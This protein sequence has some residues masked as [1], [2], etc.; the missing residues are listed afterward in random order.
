M[1]RPFFF[2]NKKDGDL[3]PVKDYQA[4]ND[5]TIKN[6][7]PLP[8]IPELID[9][10]HGA[11]YYTKFNVR[12]GYNN[13][14]IKEGDKWK[15][16]FKM[17]LGLFQPTVMTFGLCITPATIQTFMNNIFE[18]MI[19]AGQVV[20]YLDDILIFSEDLL[21]LNDLSSEVLKCLEKFD[22]YLKPEK[23]S[24]AQTSIEYLSIIISEGQ[25]RMDPAKVKGITDWP[26]P[27]TV[28]QVQAFLGFCNFYRRFIKNFLDIAHT[29]FDLTRKEAPFI[30][31]S[32]QET[33]FRTLIQAF[34][35]V[36]VLA[37]PDHSR[38][39]RLI[40]DASD[41]MTGAILELPD[42]LNCWH[43][44]ISF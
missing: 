38:P 44:V 21:T 11:C 8:L 13:I 33:S 34:V 36:P 20:V 5:I 41:F 26:T 4:L 2:V 37:L 32:P 16:A 22:P 6:A 43:P 40:T 18:D 12:W 14:L 3:R 30:W 9:K 7:A 19:D 27:R 28:K 15:A 31:A 42:A 1:A 39:F 35:T 10:L 24:F 17:P 25:I 23:F 29:L